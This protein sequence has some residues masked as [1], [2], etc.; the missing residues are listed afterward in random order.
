M[1]TRSRGFRRN[2]VSRWL[3]REIRLTGKLPEHAARIPAASKA[4]IECERHGRLTPVAASMSSPKYPSTNAALARTLG[5]FSATSSA[6]AS[7]IDGPRGGLVSS[8]AC[9]AIRNKEVMTVRR[10]GECGPVLRIASR[11]LVP[12]KLERLNDV[13]FRYKRLKARVARANRDRTLS[14]HLS[15]V[16]P[17]GGSLRL[18]VSVR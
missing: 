8:F 4:W 13:I 9:P 14:G 11:S 7:E 10:Q 15:A 6:C 17:S 3:D 18:V 1:P 5:S 2:E 12:S 16:R